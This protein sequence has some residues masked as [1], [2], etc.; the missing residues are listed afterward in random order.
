MRWE[1]LK[2]NTRIAQTGLDHRV[3][4]QADAAEQATLDHI[5]PTGQ[6]EKKRRD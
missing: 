5:D 1:K 6:A 3:R 2:R 4:K